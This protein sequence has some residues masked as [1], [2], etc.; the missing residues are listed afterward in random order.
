MK[1]VTMPGA[2]PPVGAGGMGQRRPRAAAMIG[3]MAKQV[4]PVGGGIAA[5]A[6]PAAG[7]MAGKR[8][9]GLAEMAGQRAAGLSGAKPP[10]GMVGKP[11]LGGASTTAVMPNGYVAAPNA[12]AAAARGMSPATMANSQNP[13]LQAL[14]KK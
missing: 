6:R 8:V 14:R 9:M 11:P 4:A 13:L 7:G 2:R 3:R 5:G 1:K 10:G 12:R